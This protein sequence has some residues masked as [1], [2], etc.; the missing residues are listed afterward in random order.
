MDR[1]PI[2]ENGFRKLQTEL[3]QLIKVDRP[4][5]IRDIEEA[6]AHGDLKENAEYHA[7][8]ERQGFIEGRIQTLNGILANAEIIKTAAINDDK[9]RFGATVT[10]QD[11]E[12][13]QETTWKIVGEDE[14]DIENGEISIS[15]PIARA[16][17][18]KAEG[19]DVVIHI[20]RGT[21]E[22]EIISIKYQ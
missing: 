17:L 22:V 7:A 11:V 8:K 18:G 5:I 10:Y 12:T 15:S 14:S 1:K 20:P 4:K 3:R 16:L 19:D 9:V 2:T 21:I 6:R 13:E